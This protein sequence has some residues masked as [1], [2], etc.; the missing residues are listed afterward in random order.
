MTAAV[1]RPPVRARRPLGLRRSGI[2][3]RSHAFPW[4]MR[5]PCGEHCQGSNRIIDNHF[6]DNSVKL[7]H[8][9]GRV[10]AFDL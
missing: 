9:S 5:F 1:F 4:G 2:L 10:F 7:L 6:V 3:V 8:K